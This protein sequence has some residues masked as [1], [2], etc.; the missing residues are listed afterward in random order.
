MLRLAHA[1]IQGQQPP[2]IA[3]VC[4]RPVGSP[5]DYYCT[6]Y[7]QAADLPHATAT[8]GMMT[9]LPITVADLMSGRG[10]D[11][12]VW[13]EQRALALHGSA[14]HTDVGVAALC[15][16]LKF[17]LKDPANHLTTIGHVAFYLDDP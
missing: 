2:Q 8:G 13:H 12:L 4:V 7:A 3:Q 9:R 10:I 15:Q 11:I 16:G 6:R 1:S 5:E 17:D 14:A